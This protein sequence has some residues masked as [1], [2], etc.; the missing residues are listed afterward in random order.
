MRKQHRGEWKR[1]TAEDRRWRG[2]GERNN[3][4]ADFYDGWLLMWMHHWVETRSTMSLWWISSCTKFIFSSGRLRETGGSGRDRTNGS[5]RRFDDEAAPIALAGYSNL[6][7][8]CASSRSRSTAGFADSPP[9]STS[10]IICVP[11][12]CCF[13][14]FTCSSHSSIAIRRK[15]KEKKTQRREKLQ[16]KCLSHLIAL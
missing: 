1:G 2:A 6:H 4:A 14:G 9:S 5:E 11:P 12:W 13:W 10:L 3:V 15:Q 7:F 16:A 8:S